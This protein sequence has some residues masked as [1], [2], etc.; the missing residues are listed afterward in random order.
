MT[1]DY[2]SDGV[3]PLGCSCAFVH[4]GVLWEGTRMQLNP[5]PAHSILTGCENMSAA[6]QTSWL[7]HEHGCV[8][9]V[10]QTLVSG[11]INRSL[12]FLGCGNPEFIL[13]ASSGLPMT[14]DITWRKA[15][16]AK[17]EMPIPNLRQAEFILKYIP[18]SLLQM[19]NMGEVCY[20]RGDVQ[21]LLSRKASV[22]SIQLGNMMVNLWGQIIGHLSG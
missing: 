12:P 20:T 18:I 14:L 16:A 8:N 15:V 4:V 7:T 21:D 6:L 22:F 2:P 11:L 5:S 1:Q 9:G 17:E 3:Q 13:H 10:P 19:L